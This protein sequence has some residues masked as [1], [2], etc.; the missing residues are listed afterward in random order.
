[1]SVNLAL[2]V[3]YLS[4]LQCFSLSKKG[5]VCVCVCV[6]VSSEVCANGHLN[7]ADVTLDSLRAL[8]SP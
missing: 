8:R 2:Y 1:M 6:L 7:A 3:Q 4:M 5:N